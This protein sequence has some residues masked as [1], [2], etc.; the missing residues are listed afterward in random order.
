[1]PRPTRG[2]LTRRTVAGAA[3]M[4][5]LTAPGAATAVQERSAPMFS[6]PSGIA[7][8]GPWIV[9]ANQSSS[10]L[11]V[12]LASNGSLVGH[13]A[14]SVVGVPRPTSI[15]AE[16][17]SGRRTVF[18]AGSG[19]R[20]A[21]LS[22]ASNGATLLVHRLGVVRPT[23]CTSK[24][25]GALTFDRR[26]H[27][28]E[29]C[30][31]GVVTEWRAASRVVVR[32]ITALVTGV[33]DATGI[34]ALGSDVAV[35]NAATTSPRS[36]PDGVALLSLTTGR[37]LKVA[38]NATDAANGFSSPDAISS[39]GTDFWVVNTAGNTVDELSGSTLAL[40]GSS[41]TNLTNP[42]VVLATPSFVWVSSASSSWT[43]GSSMVTQFQVVD[44]AVSSP[45]MMCNSNGPYQF[46]DPSG[47]ALHGSTLWVS[48]ASNGL[49]DEMDA[50]T[51]ALLATYS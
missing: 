44:H 34:A 3:L 12:L 51:G 37:L 30:S 16:T 28:L 23:G 21:E 31:N 41:G 47:F 4:V 42:G 13:V 29:A 27:L 26:G 46:D 43:G 25:S 48:N 15:V 1:M 11:T 14:R 10:T 7:S 36:A 24:A 49:I 45:W 6:T 18:V 20:I 40:L 8:I 19:G 9:V 5:V 38:T 50:S 2:S 33:T 32:T 22:I 39:D 35:T 17:I